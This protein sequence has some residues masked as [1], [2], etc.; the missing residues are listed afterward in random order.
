MTHV[1]LPH[2]FNPMDHVM[3]LVQLLQGV[4]RFGVDW[5]EDQVLHHWGQEDTRGH[6]SISAAAE[7]WRDMVQSQQN[8]YR[9]V[10]GQEKRR[11]NGS[12]LKASSSPA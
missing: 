3:Q 9:P 11:R 4:A 7:G 1:C 8:P 2:L 12:R 5:D 6:L 10:A